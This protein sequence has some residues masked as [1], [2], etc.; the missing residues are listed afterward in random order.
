M[1]L[2][3]LNSI[4]QFPVLGHFYNMAIWGQK[5]P[6]DNTGFYGWCHISYSI[7]NALFLPFHLCLIGVRS[8]NEVQKMHFKFLSLIFITFPFIRFLGEP[9]LSCRF[10]MVRKC[11]CNRSSCARFG[12][13]IFRQITRNLFLFRR[14]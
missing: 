10:L 5:M 4:V 6:V 8:K 13:K 14:V 11:S 7:Y 2:Q 9:W 12:A 3:K 1:S